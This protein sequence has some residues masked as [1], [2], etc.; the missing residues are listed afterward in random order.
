MTKIK[1]QSRWPVKTWRRWSWRSSLIMDRDL[2]IEFIGN[3]FIVQTVGLLS[4][5]EQ[6]HFAFSV[7]RRL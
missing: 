1:K 4:S 3:I 7:I 5:S 6:S 2:A